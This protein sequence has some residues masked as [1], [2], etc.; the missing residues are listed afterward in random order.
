M[1][2]KIKANDPNGKEMTLAEYEDLQSII[3]QLCELEGFQND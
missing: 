2:E 1:N 3:V